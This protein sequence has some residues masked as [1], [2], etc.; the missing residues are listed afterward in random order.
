MIVDIL[1]QVIIGETDL[2][3]IAPVWV[4]DDAVTMCMTC[5]THFT[6]LR[7]R[8][9][10]RACGK[11]VCSNCSSYKARLEYDNNRTNRVCMNCF[12]VL[13]K[14]DAKPCPKPKIHK[15]ADSVLCGY[16]Q[17]RAD[18]TKAWSKRWCML[19]D[20]FTLHVFKAKKVCVTIVVL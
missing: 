19:G 2:G 16:L 3:K 9:H 1:F 13:T 14:E 6:T 12:K 4:R 15:F 11:I 17:F 7:R 10:C 20:D 18:N 5:T 8:H